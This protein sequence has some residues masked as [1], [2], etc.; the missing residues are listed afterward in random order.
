MLRHCLI[1]P[2]TPLLSLLAPLFRPFR[3]PVRGVPDAAILPLKSLRSYDFYAAFGPHAGRK[4]V[5]SPVISAKQGSARCAPARKR[6]GSGLW[7]EPASRSQTPAAIAGVRRRVSWMSIRA[8]RPAHALDI[9]TRLRSLAL[10][11]DKLGR[12]T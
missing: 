10:L 2:V 9:S 3:P 4:G 8:P 7:E 12:A 1:H 5:F 11:L 6:W